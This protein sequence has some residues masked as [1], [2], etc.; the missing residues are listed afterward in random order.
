MNFLP[1]KAGD[2]TKILKSVSTT[3]RSQIF[4]IIKSETKTHKQIPVSNKCTL[5]QYT[6]ISYI[7]IM[8]KL[9]L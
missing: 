3:K 8:I 2:A 1:N 9:D 7:N 6:C 4:A 5:Y